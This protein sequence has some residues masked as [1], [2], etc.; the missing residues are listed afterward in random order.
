MG[1]VF[2]YLDEVLRQRRADRSSRHDLEMQRLKA[3]RR[4]VRHAYRHSP[5][6][7]QIVDARGIDLRTCEPTD[8]PVLTKRLLI[9][10]FD[11]IVTDHRI[12]RGK[13]AAFLEASNDPNELFLRKFVVTHTSGSS[14]EVGL[15]VCSSADWWRGIARTSGRRRIFGGFGYS[16]RRLALYA[17][18]G[19]HF[20]T[21]SAF[22]SI[23]RVLGAWLFKTA[24]YE[25]NEPIADTIDGL[26]RFQ[27]HWLLSY[28]S[29]LLT[30]ARA[31]RAGILKIKPR[32]LTSTGEPLSRNDQAWLEEVFGCPCL[33]MYG[34]TEHFG[35]GVAGSNDPG[36]TLFDDMLIFEPASDHVLVTNLYN[37][38]LP[39]IRYRMADTLRLTDVAS[40]YG[41]FQVAEP[42]VGRNEWIPV[43]HNAKGE[44]DF[45]SPHII[46]ELLVQGIWR[47]QMRWQNTTSFRFAICLEPA[48]DAKAKAN[49]IQGASARLREILRHKAL[50]NVSF[51]IEVVD[52]IPVDE[53][54]RKFRVVVRDPVD[55]ANLMPAD[56]MSTNR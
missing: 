19:G 28:A 14:G 6:Y 20:G 23:K 22:V 4:L 42:V 30:L 32:L 1:P 52:D 29:S 56:G 18:T 34:A 27:P 53:K 2:S 41:P 50:E 35:M 49:A 24:T 31:K 43:F 9:E 25:I 47:F 5:Y 15:F 10:H 38:T 51:T 39:L 12:T 3:F 46:N 40:P 13:I 8:F 48:M 55:M 37:R 26:N 36:M 21:V 17:A 44:E 16:L 45:V 7:K 54:T 33:N 11:E